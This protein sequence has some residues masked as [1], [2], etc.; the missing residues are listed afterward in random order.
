VQ[1]KIELSVV[2]IENAD[3]RSLAYNRGATC[4]KFTTLLE[5]ENHIANDEPE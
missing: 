5:L 4:R 2:D 1:E 3:E